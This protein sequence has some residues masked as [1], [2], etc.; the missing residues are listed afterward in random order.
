MAHDADVD[1]EGYAAA[2]ESGR[3]PRALWGM[4]GFPSAAQ[5]RAQREKDEDFDRRVR[6]FF[7]GFERKERPAWEARKGQ[8]PKVRRRRVTRETWDRIIEE[9][10]RLK[11]LVAVAKLPGMPTYEAIR[12]HMGR[13]PVFAAR[14]SE[15]YTLKPR[16]HGKAAIEAAIEALQQGVKFNDL[17]AK[18]LPG[19]ETVMKW[20]AENDAV[21][22]RVR[23]LIVPRERYTSDDRQRVVDLAASGVSFTKIAK[24][25]LPSRA[26][27]R[28]WRQKD[29]EL[30][31]QLS[32]IPRCGT[33]AYTDADYQ[34]ALE[35]V[36]EGTPLDGLKAL[37]LPSRSAI[38][39]RRRNDPRFGMEMGNAIHVY[40]RRRDESLDACW[41]QR[42][43]QNE[44]FS[45]VDGVIGRGIDAHIREEV[46]SE[47][48]LAVLDGDITEAEITRETARAFVAAYHREAGTW[49][50]RSFDATFGG[51]DRRTM[52]DTFGA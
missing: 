47:M 15:H 1:W 45:A 48:I 41:R 21:A 20:V 28:H 3:T 19:R 13:D 27:L 4:A 11:S 44:L 9:T 8:A 33:G 39:Y 12:Y 6:P 25:G 35:R 2:L 31:R 46:R 49:G 36:R 26:L 32:V 34:A 40:G 14:I 18:G 7:V 16:Q 22:A 24:M 38:Q 50:H 52:H 5:V 43:S 17:V 37:G 29:P 42:L 23:P 51:G 30:D 10:A